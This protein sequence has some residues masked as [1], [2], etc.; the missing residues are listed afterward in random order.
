[1]DDFDVAQA[2]RKLDLRVERIEQFLPSLATKDDLTSLATKEDFARFVGDVCELKT[3]GYRL[4]GGDYLLLGSLMV[5]PADNHHGLSCVLRLQ[6]QKTFVDVPK[7]LYAQVAV[8]NAEE[9]CMR[10][11]GIGCSAKLVNNAGKIHVG[12]AFLGEESIFV[13]VKKAS[14]VCRDPISLAAAV[15][16]VKEQCEVVPQALCVRLE[17]PVCPSFNTAESCGDFVS[18]ARK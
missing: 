18:E 1:M 2:V 13:G 4:R 12:K 8:V 16:E 7:V 9:S 14:I 15:D 10:M 17:L 5:L 11:F 3:G 6:L